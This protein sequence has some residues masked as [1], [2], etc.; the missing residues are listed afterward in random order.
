VR[1]QAQY[2]PDVLISGEQFGLGGLSSVRGT[3]IER[4]ISGDKGIAATFE[5]TTPE[6][7]S[8]LRALGFVDAGYI[9]NNN[10]NG[11]NKPSSDRLASVGVGL[12]YAKGIWAVSADYGRLVQGSRVPLAINPSSPQRGDSRFY[13]TLSVRL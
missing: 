1:A 10:P 12:R 11:A 3:D 2:S 6:L 4:P 13:L 8:G 9:T 7:V 5:V